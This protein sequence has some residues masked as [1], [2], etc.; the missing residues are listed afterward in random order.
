MVEMQQPCARNGGEA[1][2]GFGVG[3]RSMMISRR[4]G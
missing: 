3:S 1:V 2:R 4:L